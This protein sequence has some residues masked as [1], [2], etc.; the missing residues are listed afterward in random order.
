MEITQASLLDFIGRP[1]VRFEIPVFQ[2]VY[3]WNARQCEEFW[4]DCLRAGRT[5]LLHAWM[6][7]TFRSERIFGRDEAYGQIKR[8][9]DGEFG[10]SLERLFAALETYADRYF[11]DPVMREEA[12]ASAELWIAGKPDALISEYKMFGD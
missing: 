7:D 12:D 2:R 6:A 5:G 8:R 11:S 4:E 10:G 3:S 9:L 1:G